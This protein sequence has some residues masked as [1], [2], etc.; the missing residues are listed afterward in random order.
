[1]ELMANTYLT[2]IQSD[3]DLTLSDETGH[4]RMKNILAKTQFR[5]YHDPQESAAWGISP[6]DTYLGRDNPS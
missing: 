5:L 4:S 2:G 1:M 6:I 3:S